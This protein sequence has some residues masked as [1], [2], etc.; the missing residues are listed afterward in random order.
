MNRL[1]FYKNLAAVHKENTPNDKA[2]L[3]IEEVAAEMP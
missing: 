3:D 2:H 1:N